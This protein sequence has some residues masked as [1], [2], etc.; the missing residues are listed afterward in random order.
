M[1]RASRTEWTAVAAAV[2]VAA[3]LVFGLRTAVVRDASRPNVEFFPDMVRGPAVQ[4][5]TDGVA[6]TDGFSDI[7]LPEGV[8]VRGTSPFHYGAT[9]EEAERAGR[10]LTSPFSADDAA[11][12][13]RGAVVY[14]RFCVV[15][16][17]ADGE[18]KGTA[19]VRGMLPPP[20]LKAER[21]VQMRDGQLFHVITRG[22]GNMASY[23]VQVRP[24]DRWKA[25]L[26][27]RALQAGGAR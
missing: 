12:R 25:I 10:E 20:S 19:V 4:S 1:T 15:C 18:G 8:V 3:V 23:A 26:H 5:Q 14:A 13:E 6:T 17:G 2:G 27:V 22:Q 7:A 11:A 9:P 16:H 21:A 24:E